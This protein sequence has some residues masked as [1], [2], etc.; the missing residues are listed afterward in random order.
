L[1]SLAKR[2]ASAL[3][4]EMRLRL[5]SGGGGAYVAGGGRWMRVLQH[6]QLDVKN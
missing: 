3:S 5:S 2:G 1:F 4:P 6:K